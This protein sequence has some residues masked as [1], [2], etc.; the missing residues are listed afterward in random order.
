MVVAAAMLLCV[1]GCTTVLPEIAALTGNWVD[2]A[3][4]SALADAQALAVFKEREERRYRGN[5]TPENALRLAVVL[6][7]PQASDEELEAG[8]ELL[9]RLAGPEGGLEP[10]QQDVA[11]S[12]HESAAALLETRR[13]RTRLSGEVESLRRE[14]DEANKKIEELLQIER[15]IEHNRGRNQPEGS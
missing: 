7:V 6:T 2:L 14:L 15:S 13:Q 8:V 1:Q 9:A 12:R 4:R 3:G 5:P 11:R 10:G